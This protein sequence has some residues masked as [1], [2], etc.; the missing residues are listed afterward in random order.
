MRTASATDAVAATTL[1]QQA[2]EERDDE[3]PPTAGRG[4][5]NLGPRRH[6]VLQSIDL[7]T[8]ADIEAVSRA[9]A[10]AEG[11]A[12]RW[13]EVASLAERRW[14]RP[15]SGAPWRRAS[16]TANCT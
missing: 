15:W 9:Q 6:G 7:A 12:D 13:R 11:I 2:K 14:S 8:G 16:T 1:A 10:A 4:G 3:N 5:T